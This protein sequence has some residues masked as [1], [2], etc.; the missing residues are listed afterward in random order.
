MIAPL[1][2]Y[3]PHEQ[4]LAA[5][6]DTIDR[7]AELGLSGEARDSLL[8]G[9]VVWAAELSNRIDALPLDQLATLGDQ[10]AGHPILGRLL[11]VGR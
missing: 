5:C 1:R 4:Y 9:L 2:S 6:R 11:G 3:L 7:E 10:L 8:L